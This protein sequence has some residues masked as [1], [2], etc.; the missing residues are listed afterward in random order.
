MISVDCLLQFVQDWG[1][2]FSA[3]TSLVALIIAL[4]ALTYTVRSFSRKEGA[5]IRATFAVQS[6]IASTQKN[7]YELTLENMKD[8]SVAIYTIY[9]RLGHNCY[10]ELEDFEES[11][12]VLES[13]GTYSTQYDPVDFYSDNMRPIDINEL[14][15]DTRQQVVL[16]T[17]EG[18]YVVKEWIKKWDPVG[19]YFRNYSTAIM[20]PMRVKL[21]GKGYGSNAKFVVEFKHYS[22]EVETI[23]IYSEDYQGRR[24][25]N[26]MLTEESL[27]SEES[28]ETFLRDKI[29][30]GLLDCRDF[31][32]WNMVA[33]RERAYEYYDSETYQATPTSWFGHYALGRFFTVMD[34]L[35]TRRSNKRRKESR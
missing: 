20:L 35:K 15:K 2:F 12:L 19:D 5:R 8:R 32:I 27:E 26:F 14:W 33:A 16:S 30:E 23:P 1:N 25:K 7:V 9:F 11:P 21:K 3:V 10:I 29:E 34:V 18:K 17:S 31:K 13:F 6:T 24:F 28:L 4:I 22:G